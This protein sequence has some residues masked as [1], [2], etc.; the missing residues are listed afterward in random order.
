M[1]CI[2]VKSNSLLNSPEIRLIAIYRPPNT[3]FE[4]F[5][6]KFELILNSVKPKQETYIIGD[7]NIN[8]L[9]SMTNNTLS[10]QNTLYS[11]CFYPLITALTRITVTTSSLI[12]NIFTNTSEPHNNGIVVSDFSD[13]FPIYTITN[14]SNKLIH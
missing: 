7:F 2:N 3:H 9:D 12:D 11:H 5:L 13:H 14:N 8:F 4:L 6:N 10:F 1:L